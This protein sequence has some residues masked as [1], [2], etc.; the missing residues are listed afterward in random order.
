MPAVIDFVNITS[1]I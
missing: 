1:G